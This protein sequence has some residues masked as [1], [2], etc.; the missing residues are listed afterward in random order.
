MSYTVTP[1]TR[2][3]DK[4]GDW[5]TRTN[6]VIDALN[7]IVVTTAA[8]TKGANT[9]GNGFVVGIFGSNTLVAASLQGGNI[10][11]P[12]TL[13]VVTNLVSNAIVSVGNT[14]ANVW[15]NSIYFTVVNSTAQLNL[16]SIGV[17]VGQTTLNATVLFI[18]N[19]TVNVVSNNTVLKL[20]GNLQINSSALQIGNSTVNV[21][22]NSTTY[23][24]GANVTLSS[25]TFFMGNSTANLL[26]NS[27]SIA[28]ANSTNSAIIQSTQIAVGHVTMNA[29]AFNVEGN[30]V[31]NA[32]TFAVGNST[33]NVVI[34]SSSLAV[35][36]VNAALITNRAAASTYARGKFNF[37]QGDNVTI[38]ISDDSVGGQVNVTIAATTV[39]GSGIVAGSNTYIQFN[40][41]GQFGGN[42][43]FTY[44]KATNTVNIAN[45]LTVNNVTTNNYIYPQSIL[46]TAFAF[47]N[48]TS[49]GP[50]QIDSFVMAT[51]RSANYYYSIKNDGANGYQS[52]M[53]MI[54][55]DDT[56]ASLEEFG[57]VY[58]NTL[59]G[60]FSTSANA[61]HILV[62]FTPASSLSYTIKAQKTLIPV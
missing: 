24:A 44:S 12:A 25:T 7:T 55:N 57:V 11:N 6:T 35:A 28:V 59:L 26:A 10:G 31:M 33:V 3:T 15:S 49:T 53:L 32:T 50:D 29:L 20:S 38:D 5:I 45:T 46:S 34:N 17:T 16:S 47:A 27:T 56:A 52:G 37:I 60:A 19:S 23:A 18:G 48:V 21:V 8:N 42:A 62:R 22:A 30:T 51:Y 36:G 9:S 4:F 58:S 39:D 40:N 43:G 61:T 54:L 1:I 2:A 13:N 41:S 14:T